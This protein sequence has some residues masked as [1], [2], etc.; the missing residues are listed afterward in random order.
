MGDV[1]SRRLPP[2]AP[3]PRSQPWVGQS[4]RSR[5][6]LPVLRPRFGDSFFRYI[7]VLHTL[8]L[9]PGKETGE[10]L[11][12]PFAPLCA[13]PATLVRLVGFR[14]LG[15]HDIRHSGGYGGMEHRM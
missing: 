15:W 9:S 3:W 11:E 13:D 1:L 12:F 14:S 10:I 5:L 4:H 8:P 2:V 6:R 7:G